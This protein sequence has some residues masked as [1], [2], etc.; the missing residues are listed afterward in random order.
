M[1]ALY[2]YLKIREEKVEYVFIKL[3]E[4][5]NFFKIQLGLKNSKFK[6]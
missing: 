1:L 5:F 4:N 3:K 2:I 6:I